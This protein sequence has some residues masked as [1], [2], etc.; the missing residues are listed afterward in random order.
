M[1]VSVKELEKQLKRL[2]S[3][4]QKLTL[5]KD[6]VNIRKK[7]LKQTIKIPFSK[8]GKNR[9][10]KDITDDLIGH[11]QTYGPHPND[12]TLQIDD[13]FELVGKQI[14]HQFKHEGE[15]NNY[16]IVAKLSAMMISVKNTRSSMITKK[17]IVAS[18]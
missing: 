13:P 3:N 4:Q 8:Q 6:Q 18:I 14:F 15:E 5:L 12:T 9:P 16:G 1:I 11:I 7:L 17:G 2:E 10:L